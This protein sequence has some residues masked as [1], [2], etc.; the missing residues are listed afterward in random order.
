[1]AY[2]TTTPPRL[3]VPSL[4]GGL[5]IWGYQSTDGSTAVVQADY[6]SNGE[7]L[8]MRVGDIV[9][10]VMSTGTVHSMGSVSAVSTAATIVTGNLQTTL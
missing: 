9:F 4:G 7:A 10:C 1:M 6:F 5:Q 8:G 3:L 2:A